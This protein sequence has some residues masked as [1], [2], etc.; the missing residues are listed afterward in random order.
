MGPDGVSTMRTRTTVVVA[1]MALGPM[2]WAGVGQPTPAD[3]TPR[4]QVGTM[5]VATHPGSCV[6]TAPVAVVALNNPVPSGSPDDLSA[7]LL[8]Y[9]EAPVALTDLL[10]APHAL[11]VTLGGDIDAA[12]ACGDLD[13]SDQDGALSVELRE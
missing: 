7:P 11:L 13:A 4:A 3:A 2:V 6:D 8:S 10:A 5:R 9:T 1:L 12:L